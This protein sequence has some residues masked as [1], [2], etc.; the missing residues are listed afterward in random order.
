MELL[1]QESK[2]AKQPAEPD[3]VTDMEFDEVENE[4][5]D[6]KNVHSTTHWATKNIRKETIVQYFTYPFILS[7]ILK[8]P[9]RKVRRWIFLHISESIKEFFQES[10]LLDFM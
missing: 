3:K 8:L 4:D 6:Y 5:M 1:L 10:I 2:D 7:Q 9:Q